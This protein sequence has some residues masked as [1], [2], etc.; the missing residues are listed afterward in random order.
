MKIIKLAFQNDQASVDSVAITSASQAIQQILPQ[1]QTLN[2]TMQQLANIP[3]LKT[4][5]SFQDAMNSVN[6]LMG[7]LGQMQSDIE[8]K[9]S[10]VQINQTNNQTSF[11]QAVKNNT[12]S[13]SR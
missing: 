11:Q 8:T 13:Q 12:P 4:V 9:M 5:Q 7:S 1:A 6:Q 3:V 2:D 10:Q